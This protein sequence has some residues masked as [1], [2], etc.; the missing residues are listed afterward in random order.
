MSNY[1][2]APT[3]EAA[4][5]PLIE[6]T[7]PFDRILVINDGSTDNS[8]EVLKRIQERA[9]QIEILD[10]EKNIGVMASS[11]IGFERLTEDFVF[12]ASANDIFSTRLVEY[13]TAALA[14]MPHAHM[15]AGKI[16]LRTS[17]GVEQIISL[18]F[19]DGTISTCEPEL[20]RALARQ[21][22]F[23]ASGG[24]VFLNR[25]TAIELGGFRDDFKWMSDWFLY[26]Q[27]SNRHGFVYVPEQFSTMMVSD[28]QYSSRVNDWRQQGPIIRSFFQTMQTEYPKELDDFRSI[29][30][31]P[32]YDWQIL[33]MLLRDAKL[34]S[35]ISPLLLWR[36]A[37]SKPARTIARK[38]LP[39]RLFNLVRQW[40]RL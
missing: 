27:I 30:L 36:L 34:R 15:V 9:P 5:T 24:G 6:Q 16:G 40:V 28:N 22:P 26:A 18:P 31:L 38:L 37:L 32:S 23:S 39:R 8:M 3:L 19:A 2:D 33:P 17:D 29:A 12:P 1:N 14:H 4:L 35:Y 10:N 11:R 25:K 13:A 21:R 20:Y 7:I